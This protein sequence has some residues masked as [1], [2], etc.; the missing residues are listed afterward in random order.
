M[1]Y[2]VVYPNCLDK[3]HNNQKSVNCMSV[4]ISIGSNEENSTGQDITNSVMIIYTVGLLTALQN[5]NTGLSNF[6][7]KP[8]KC[9]SI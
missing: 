5:G 6:E 2:N 7:I 1:F 9:P 8:T 4:Y 3:S